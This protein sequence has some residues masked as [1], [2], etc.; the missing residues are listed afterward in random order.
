LLELK[1]PKPTLSN[2]FSTSVTNQLP[3]TLQYLK[4]NWTLLLLGLPAIL[5]ILAF[6][7]FPMFGTV[8]AFQDYSPKTG[9]F[10]PFVGLRNFRLLWESP[11]V[12]RLVQNTIGL[13]L[14]FIVSTTFFSV[15]VAL[16]LNEVRSIT[17]K[18]LT[19]SVMFLPFFM[20]WTLVSLVLYGLIDY[21]VGTINSVL[22]KFGMERILLT[23]K[24]ELWPWILTIIRIWKGTGAGCIIYLAALS[25]VDQQ[26]YEAAAIDGA[27]RWARMRYISLP[28]ILPVIV[29]LTLMSI[30]GIFFGDYGMLYAIIGNK[31]S[32][33]PTT[34]VI[35]TYVIRALRNNANFGMSTA[36][37]LVQSVLGFIC[38]FGS[39]W[40]V[41]KYSTRR[42]ENLALF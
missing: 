36:V 30:G 12:L 33:F 16:L 15:L 1:Q 22:V 13:N 40:L 27:G 29:I 31:A 19:Q 6:S 26:L 9:F 5:F 11:V 7:Y 34:D 14:M 21:Q 17:F 38:V 39:N 2:T 42:G 24:P 4:D 25:G 8:I 28:S 10:S 41:R 23:D 37:G 35:D 20:G 18:R 3:K 32:L